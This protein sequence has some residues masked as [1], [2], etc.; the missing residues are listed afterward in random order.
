MF[1]FKIL[2]NTFKKF[3]HQKNKTDTG[4]A[5]SIKEHIRE[6]ISNQIN[7]TAKL[8]HND[9]SNFFKQNL[10]KIMLQKEPLISF[11]D[12][13]GSKTKV[14]ISI[15][16]SLSGMVDI[17]SFKKTINRSEPSK[18][19]QFETKTHDCNNNPVEQIMHD[20]KSLTEKDDKDTDDDMPLSELIKMYN[21]R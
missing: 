5:A 11:E 10:T 12:M 4:K 18:E 17:N 1:I 7:D 8:N 19:N 14:N 16:D 15:S 20:G 9:N 13:C 3:L 6:Y 2:I 21:K